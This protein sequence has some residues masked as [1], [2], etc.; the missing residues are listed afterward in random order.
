MSIVSKIWADIKTT[1]SSVRHQ[2]FAFFDSLM[3]SIAKNGGVVLIDAVSA[4]VDAA[5]KEGGN[6]EEK[7]A[8]AQAA[9]IATLQKEGIPVV[10]NA[11]NGAIEAAVAQ[12]KS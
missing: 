10:I 6:G 7:F 9:V 4:A 2:T 12:Q 1:L 5:E 3:A 8:R 11:I